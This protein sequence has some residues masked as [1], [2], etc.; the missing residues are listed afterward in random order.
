MWWNSSCGKKLIG[1]V[2][3]VKGDVYNVRSVEGDVYKVEKGV[4]PGAVSS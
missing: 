3:N 1:V 2:K 4:A